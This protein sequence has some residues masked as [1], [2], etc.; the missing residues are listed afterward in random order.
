MFDLD[1][2]V[3]QIILAAPGVRDIWL[4][5]SRA[6]G[7][8]GPTS[9]WDLLVF[10]DQS[11]FEEVGAAKHLHRADVDCLVVSGSGAFASAWGGKSKRGSLTGWNWRPH[12]NGN[13]ATYEESKWHDAEDGAGVRTADR[14]ATRIW[15]RS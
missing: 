3:Q 2:Y 1:A 8:A 9:D 4:I 5:G 14:L 11:S 12:P 7:S 13:Q 15:P 6:N 10:G